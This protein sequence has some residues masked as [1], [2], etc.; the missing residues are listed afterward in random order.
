VRDAQ[1][2][3]R[4][5]LA[6]RRQEI[7]AER[8]SAALEREQASRGVNPALLARYDRIRAARPRW[9]SIRCT[10]ARAATA[11]RGWSRRSAK[12]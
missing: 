4:E 1:A 9:R 2:A 3:Q 6:G 10:A 8:A 12:R 5:A 11:L 7:T